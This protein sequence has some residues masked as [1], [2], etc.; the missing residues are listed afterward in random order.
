MKNFLFGFLVAGVIVGIALGGYYY[1]KNQN[2]SNLLPTPTGYVGL[3]SPTKTLV[4]N[5]A[6][7]HG[8]IG[9]AGYSWCEVKNKCLRI[10]EEPCEVKPTENISELIKQALIKKNN[11]TNG[12]DL[13]ITIS[14]NEGT[15]ISGGV[16]DKNA[17]AGGGYFFAVKAGGVWKIIADGNGTIS[18]ESL[19]P[20]P[21]YPKSFIPECWDE[22]TG[23]LIIR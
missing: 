19:V 1:G 9:S 6:D 17:E 2:N 14:K 10:F 11:W 20:Y 15:Y 12:D 22:K 8:C 21:D 5:D 13:I 4:G 3:I 18:C 7:V 16:K 23:K